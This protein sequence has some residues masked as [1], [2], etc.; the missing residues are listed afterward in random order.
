MCGRHC[1]HLA[2]HPPFYWKHI[3]Q[4]LFLVGLKGKSS[5]G[6]SPWGVRGQN[7]DRSLSASAAPQQ[8]NQQC[9]QQG[10][11]SCLVLWWHQQQVQSLG[12]L[13]G[14]WKLLA[15]WA[16]PPSILSFP[17]TSNHFLISCIKSQDSWSCYAD[18]FL[19]TFLNTS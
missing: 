13:Q 1:W 12:L 17:R 10:C 14:H 15:V 7:G 5:H 6:R 18:F 19:F 9:L 8:K 3:Y 2:P 16:I 4:T 11:T